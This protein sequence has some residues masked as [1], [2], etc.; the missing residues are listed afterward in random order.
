MNVNELLGQEWTTLQNNHEQYEKGGL[1]I[2]LISVLLTA[3]GLV[4][5]LDTLLMGALVALLWVQEGIFRTFQA[6]LGERILRVEFLMRQS[7]TGLSALASQPVAQG[8]V[9]QLHSEWLA[10]RRQGMGLINEYARSAFRPTVAFPYVLI[11]LGFMI[12]AQ[13]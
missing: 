4:F 12:G 1:H 9:F 3:A 6:R 5:G 13:G 7:T 10:A 11:L 8:D 2:K